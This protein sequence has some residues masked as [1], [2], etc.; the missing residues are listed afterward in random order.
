MYF[1]FQWHAHTDI[2]KWITFRFPLS[3]IGNS[4]QYYM[5]GWLG[6]EFVGE[7]MYVHIL[8]SRSAVHLRLSHC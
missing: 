8:L 5:A 4:A 1:L 2:L 6:D 7:W 3:S